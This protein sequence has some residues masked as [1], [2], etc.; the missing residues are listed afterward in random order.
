MQEV[1]KDLF[2]RLVMCSAHV[3]LLQICLHIP[4]R[5]QRCSYCSVIRTRVWRQRR[6]MPLRCAEVLNRR[7]PILF[8]VIQ[9]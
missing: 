5:T 2:L 4:L 8:Q 1:I 6:L 9:H 3:Q 7:E